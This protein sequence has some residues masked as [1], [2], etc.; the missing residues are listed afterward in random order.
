MEVNDG[1]AE[2]FFFFFFFSSLPPT[3]PEWFSIVP[4][5][6]APGYRFNSIA[7]MSRNYHL[8]LAIST[9]Q[10]DVQFSNY[11]PA[12]NF[13]PLGSDLKCD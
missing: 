5:L 12:W 4:F 11:C 3:L 10:V 13:Y 6:D 2:V 8:L 9:R 7:G 1:A